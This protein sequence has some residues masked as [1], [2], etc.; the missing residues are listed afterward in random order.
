MPE[1]IQ[2]LEDL[3]DASPPV[4]EKEDVNIASW[5]RL[6]S[7]VAGAGLVAA[8]LARRSWS[9]IGLFALGAGLLHRGLSGHCMV[10]QA[11]SLDRKHESHPALGVCGGHGAKYEASLYV[12]RSP[13]DVYQYW[14]KLENLPSVMRHLVSVTTSDANRSHWVAQGPLGTEVKW[15]AEIINERK[16]EL[17]A[18]RSLPGSEIDTAGSVAFQPGPDGQGTRMD[19][20]LK[21][22]PPGGKA[23][24]A[25]SDFFGAGLRQRMEQDLR[26]LKQKLEA[27]EVPTVEGQPR[28]GCNC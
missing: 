18:W 10:Y 11:L 3:R 24:T 17:L 2:E 1:A 15:D 5:E 16:N 7:T 22:D 27:G 19:V 14:R 8:G 21:Y 13:E 20:S 6:A 25:L 26:R 4:G 12:Q 9:S 23:T 28:G